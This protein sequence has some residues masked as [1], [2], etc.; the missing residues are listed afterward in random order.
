MKPSLSTSYSRNAPETTHTHILL[1]LLG[2]EILAWRWGKQVTWKCLC[3]LTKYFLQPWGWRHHFPPKSF[4]LY[5]KLHSHRINRVSDFVHLA[6]SKELEDKNTSRVQSLRLALPKGPNRVGVSP[7]LRTETHPVSEMS[8]F[9]ILI[10]LESGRW[11]KSE[12]PLILC[13]THHR[14]NPIR[15]ESTKLHSSILRTD[16]QF[17]LKRLYLCSKLRFTHLK[18]KHYCPSKYRYLFPK[19]YSSNLKTEAS[20][21]S[22]T[23]WSIYQ[24]THHKSFIWVLH[25]RKQH[26]GPVG[27]APWSQS[28]HNATSRPSSLVT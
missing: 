16:A 17:S 5:T 23:F 11:T 25:N 21:F 15:L 6:D 28:T 4:Y 7:H 24:S 18:G 10:F 20:F 19:L 8:S 22:I 12:N 2:T 26:S 14:Q 3:L 13:V 27:L 9:Y 1:Y